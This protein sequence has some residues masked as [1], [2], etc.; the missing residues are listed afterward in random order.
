MPNDPPQPPQRA[1]RGALP[2]TGGP[3]KGGPAWKGSPGPAAAARKPWSRKTKLT[4]GVGLLGALA[5]LFVVVVLLPRPVKPFRLVLLSAGY[6]TDLA[7]PHNVP[8]R[9]TVAKLAAWAGANEK[10]GVHRPDL[11]RDLS[12]L[13]EALKDCKSPTVVLFLAAHGAADE[14]G[15]YL[16]PQ[17]ASDPVQARVRLTDILDRLEKL[18]TGTKKL[19]I[20]DATQVPASWTFG[21][22]HND[23]AR[24]LNKL[25]ERIERTAGLVVLSASGEDQ[26]SWV[27]EE[28]RQ[29][30]FG[31]HVQE[32]LRGAANSGSGRITAYDLAE[33]VKDKVQRWARHNREA[34][35]E[36]V[37]LGGADRAKAMELVAVAK[38]YE[39][40]DPRKLEPF[41]VPEKLTLAW[42]DAYKL[43]T[44]PAPSPAVYT[45]HLWRRYLETLLRFE[46]LLRADADDTNANKVYDELTRLRD[47][48]AGDR[49]QKADAALVT[50]AMPAALGW[51]AAPGEDE[52]RAKVLEQRWGES[53]GEVKAQLAKWLAGARDSWQKG[54]LRV[55]LS[56]L[57]L[58][59]AAA[60]PERDL[61][62]VADLL[63]A[64]EWSSA[65]R[66]AEAQYLVLLARDLVPQ[67]PW[68]AVTDAL[69]LRRVAEEAALGMKHDAKASAALPPYSEELLS[70][71]QRGVE[72]GDKDRRPGQ[73]LLLASRAQD[74]SD[75]SK[76]L[77]KARD[78]Y[79]KAQDT[80]LKL[81]AALHARDEALAAL[82]YYSQWLARERFRDDAQKNTFKLRLREQV[83]LWKDVQ[84][85]DN[86]LRAPS[87]QAVG[88]LPDLTK[89][90][91]DKMKK[92]K[93]IERRFDQNEWP[94]LQANWHEIDN[95]LGVPCPAVKPDRRMALLTR[96]REISEELNREANEK[97]GGQEAMTAA[98][99]LALNQEQARAHGKLALLALGEEAFNK[100][101]KGDLEYGRVEQA[102]TSLNWKEALTQ[103]GDEVARRWNAL[104]AAIDARLA[105][106][107]KLDLDGERPLA[108]EAAALARR[109]SGAAAVR[110]GAIDPLEEHR[111]LQLHDLLC[112]QAER[113]S[114]DFLDR[115]TDDSDPRAYYQTSGLIYVGDARKQLPVPE[116]APTPLKDARRA[117]IKALQKELEDENRKLKVEWSFDGQKFDSPSPVWLT[118]E[119]SVPLWYGVRAAATVPPGHPV[120]WRQLEDRK[121]FLKPAATTRQVQPGVGVGPEKASVPYP[122][123][124]QPYDKPPPKLLKAK[125]VV[126]GLYR[127]HQLV[128]ETAVNHFAVPEKAMSLPMM[129]DKSW[130]AVQAPRALY[131]KYGEGRGAVVLILDCSGS[132]KAKQKNGNTRFDEARAAL[133]RVLAEIPPSTQ[134]S[135]WVFS[136]RF[137]VNNP[138]RRFDENGGTNPEEYIQR[139]YF[140][141]KWDKTKLAEVEPRIDELDYYNETPIV[142]AMIKARKD[143]TAQHD[144]KT[145]VVLTDGMDNR[146]E[147]QP[148]QEDGTKWD[149]DPVLNPG[150]DPEGK[151]PG[152][153]LTIPQFLAKA[154]A[155]DDIAIRVVGFQ[156]SPK[157][158]PVAEQ[159]FKKPLEALPTKGKFYLAKD[160]KALIEAL[161]GSI[162]QRLY[163]SLEK[164]TG[165][166]I[167]RGKNE[168]DISIVGDDPQPIPLNPGSYRVVI[169]ASGK[170]PLRQKIELDRGDR[171][172]LTLY[173]RGDGFVLERDLVRSSFA[174]WVRGEKDAKDWR[175]TVLQNQRAR[176]ED[177]LQMTVTAENLRLREF[178]GEG[179]L[180]HIRPDLILFQV[181]PKD[182]PEPAR[183]TLRYYPLASLT[184]PSWGLDVKPWVRTAPPVLEAFWSEG[185]PRT[186][187]VFR[188]G[189]NFKNLQ[190]LREAASL[191]VQLS[192]K[193]RGAVQLV[194][195]GVKEKWVE[196]YDRK[197]QKISCLVVRLSFPPGQAVMA[198]LPDFDGGQEHRFYTKAGKYTGLFEMSREDARRVESLNLISLQAFREA[199]V[200]SGQHARIPLGAPDRKD[201]P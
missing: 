55:R 195:I 132:M 181:S 43:A 149:G 194:S 34:R 5:G 160:T 93:A 82:P 144:L 50:L 2:S 101:P 158:E 83:V 198:Q 60:T 37:L 91:T 90:V 136:H 148:R 159:Q 178:A 61:K 23:F 62:A 16:I 89:T 109:L 161:R 183:V 97:A 104:P 29:S 177:A 145:M 123:D 171:L 99:T 94:A 41:R 167:K 38:P 141:A 157:E 68:P 13:D 76:H 17:D 98:E 146:F 113:T 111:R 130:L 24:Q 19:L 81:R 77:A 139:L 42:G 126:R 135:V 106:G 102:T 44:P 131:K 117:R 100:G 201:R 138:K 6:E 26:R 143:F 115:A 193:V 116:R 137:D 18:P 71:I 39:A 25:K 14:H 190:V 3:A 169:E 74:W 65:V 124:R 134:V 153:K 8:G 180:R 73:D 49:A 20:L 187:G 92:V 120:L 35:Q 63:T 22:F 189:S 88:Q 164:S 168:K 86:L 9:K 31:H 47:R 114:L 133:K 175:L 186:V 72:D 69:D 129:P 122:L 56:G 27:S 85:L 125:Q 46:Q 165:E 170:E 156:L 155:K 84:R 78:H 147:P 154:F 40:P 197:P 196:T 182:E 28:W 51:P 199:A 64:T 30:I 67:P 36:P 12:A 1:W 15:A 70:W 150:G 142:R 119:D 200:D 179:T 95:L 191:D 176:D 10:I 7:V 45:P 103:A 140:A 96:L 59:Q 121:G 58:R 32:G 162:K 66:P 53:Q 166:P 33:Y 163:F 192:K 105:Q 52:T 75:A 188:Q 172:R 57:L 152:G 184:A 173:A 87:P 110:L 107:R 174:G 128:G 11:T 118:D 4:L 80:A 108:R 54:L 151:L 127:G 112:W 48:I 185:P 21:F 79:Q